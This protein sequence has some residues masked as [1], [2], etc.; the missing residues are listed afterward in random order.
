MTSFS[1]IIPTRDRPH[2]LRQALRSVLAQAHADI[3]TI[4][5]NDGT[6]GAE[7]ANSVSSA[8][9]VLD[10]RG[11]GPVAARIAGVAAA[12]GE[13]IAF[14]DDDDRFTDE[15]YL[16]RAARHF[17]EGADFCF[18]DGTLVFDD[19]RADLPFSY[20]ADA[21]SLARD[22]TILISAVSYRR[23]LHDRLGR[24]DET[25]PYYWDW[26]WYLRVA[27]SGAR[28]WHDQNPV[29]AIRLHAENMSGESLATARRANLDRLAEKH[30]L[31]PLALKNH[32][33]LAREAQ[34]P[35]PT[36]GATI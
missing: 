20:T 13:A 9:R 18:A 36:P 23:N 32:L 25:L 34:K 31:A 35:R 3:E 17:A 22:N 5:V 4:V 2:Y 21:S 26:D 33:D 16:A 29:V 6:G 8:I 27:G 24:F 30:K 28:L 15:M 12:R 19:G 11:Q 7:I 14:L 1:V 10:S